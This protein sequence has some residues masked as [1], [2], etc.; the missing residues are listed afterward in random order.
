MSKK[1]VYGD[2][3]DDDIMGL[4]K[5]FQSDFK[6][7]YASVSDTEESERFTMFKKNLITIDSLNRQNPLALFGITEAGDYTEEERNTKK[8]SP[9]YSSYEDILTQLP[10]EMVKLAQKGPS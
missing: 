9:K 10:S 3:S 2:M 6:R 5:Q 8:M 1:V 7:D 4:F